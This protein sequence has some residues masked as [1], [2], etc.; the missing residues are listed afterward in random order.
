MAT[1]RFASAARARIIWGDSPEEAIEHLRTQGATAEEAK[2][3]VESVGDERSQIIRQS[4]RKKIVQGILLISVPFIAGAV[5]LFIRVVPMKLFGLCI[6]AGL[7]GVWKLIRGILGTV[8]PD[9]IHGDL[10]DDSTE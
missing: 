2:E 8:R 5:F 10:S 7:I 6:V 4:A 9:M 1:E 3:A